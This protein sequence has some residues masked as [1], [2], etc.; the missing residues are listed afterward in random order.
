MRNLVLSSLFLIISCASYTKNFVE[1]E[2][3]FETFTPNYLENFQEA[4]FKISIDA[5][6]NHFGGI[7]AAKK[8]EI[9]HYRFAF[10]NEFG[11]KLLDFELIN[12][13]LKLN[14]AVDGLN[15]KILLKLLEK[16]FNLTF[17]ENNRVE[18]QFQN[19][20]FKILKSSV[21]NLKKPVY[22]F[23]DSK[24]GKLKKIVL[25]NQKEEISVNLI[26]TEKIWPDVEISHQKMPIK[27][28]LHL[29]D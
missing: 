11:G 26:S 10:V 1:K 23:L 4:S 2:K 28:Y 24:T 16:D 5:F 7:L 13:E 21:G 14:Y 19:E 17:S 25:A 29:L 27:I 15:R 20:Q 18:N 3:Q 9:N 12:N 22:Y 6:G 8:L